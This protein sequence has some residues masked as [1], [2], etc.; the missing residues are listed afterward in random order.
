MSGSTLRL[1]VLFY[2]VLSGVGLIVMTRFV[3]LESLGLPSD[4][5]GSLLGMMGGVA[6]GGGIVLLS[7]L[8]SRFAVSVRRLEDGFRSILGPMTRGQVAIAA[9]ASSVGEEILFRG[10]M[11]PLLGLWPTALIF[12]VLHRGPTRLFSVWPLL[13]FGAGVLLGGLR[14]WSGSVWPGVVAHVLINALNL[15]Y[16]VGEKATEA[17]PGGALQKEWGEDDPRG[18]I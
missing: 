8:G 2:F 12:G 5:P 15:D 11:Q 13:A 1:L 6:V 10:A 7:R 18:G 17:L 3:G 16:L 14:E 9:L 4:P